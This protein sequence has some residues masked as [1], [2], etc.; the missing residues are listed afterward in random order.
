[1][2]INTLQCTGQTPE[3]DLAQKI[4]SAEVETLCFSL[5]SLKKTL[6]SSL[7]LRDSLL[8]Q[9]TCST[10]SDYMLLLAN[11][12][13]SLGSLTRLGVPLILELCPQN[14]L[15]SRLIIKN[16][17]GSTGK[18]LVTGIIRTMELTDENQLHTAHIWSIQ[19]SQSRA[20]SLIRQ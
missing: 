1:M 7:I 17:Y 20:H 8:I 6:L 2:L 4:N 14:V 13:V 15:N 18:R 12:H 3:N 5:T 11:S 10:G 9:E 19:S 16:R